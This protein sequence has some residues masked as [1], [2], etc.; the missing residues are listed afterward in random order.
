MFIST[1][2]VTVISVPCIY[3]KLDN[4]PSTARFLAKNEQQMAVERLRANQDGSDEHKIQWAQIL[5]TLTDSKTY[6]FLALS[7]GINLGA[8]VTTT[9]GPLIMNGL[10]YDSQTAIL[11]NIPFG[12]LQYIVVLGIAF[13]ATRF[14]W[15]SLTL[16]MSLFPV[17]IGLV[18]LFIV[19]HTP[20]NQAF[21]LLGYH[22]LSFILSFNGLTIF[23]ILANTAG[24]TKKATMMSLYNAA[25][26][27]GNIIGPILFRDSD[28]PK[29]EFGLKATLGVYIVVFWL[30]IILVANLVVLNRMQETKRISR[31]KPSKL[32]DHSMDRSYTE[33]GV[34][35]GYVVGNFAFADLTD[36]QNDEF[37]YV[38]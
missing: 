2:L 22:L 37:V 7:I 33:V 3:G 16:G 35:D 19:P 20:N 27:V 23:W 1:G 32:H 17:I 12:A 29:Y 24:Q 15:Q 26:A 13:I 9:F 11:F 6:L 28:A 25:A 34:V 8:Q 18:I 14:R 4:E 10:G 30:V 5:D 21:L 31:G 38:Y 36:R